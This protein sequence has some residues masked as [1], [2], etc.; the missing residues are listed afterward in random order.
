MAYTRLTQA[1]KDKA[2]QAAELLRDGAEAAKDSAETLSDD[3][4]WLGGKLSAL[5]TTATGIATTA[6]G[7]ALILETGG[8]AALFGGG[9]AVVGGVSQTVSGVSELLGLV[10]ETKALVEGLPGA[11]GGGEGGG[12]GVYGSVWT[13]ALIES[14]VDNAQGIADAVGIQNSIPLHGVA[15][16]LREYLLGFLTDVGPEGV[17]VPDP[18]NTSALSIKQAAVASQAASVA[19]ATLLHSALMNLGRYS[20][21]AAGVEAFNTDKA[22]GSVVGDGLFVLWTDG[23]SGEQVPV[24]NPQRLTFTS[25]SGDQVFDLIQMVVDVLFTLNLR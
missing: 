24:L 17:N 7:T 4:G 13:G 8:A 1:Q 22:E 21:D 10:E 12:G 5:A 3:D 18:I 6:A 15:N 11:G 14:V 23:Q 25:P 19:T 20:L 2:L 16:Q 9:V